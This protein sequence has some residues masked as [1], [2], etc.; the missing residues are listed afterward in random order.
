MLALAAGGGSL[1]LAEL[2]A[3]VCRKLLL[4]RTVDAGEVVVVLLAV[5]SR[6][7]E[8]HRLRHNLVV[9]VQA[10]DVANGSEVDCNSDAFR[11]SETD[12]A[13]NRESITISRL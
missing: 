7:L 10:R 6:G 1:R 12:S 9:S 13:T 11:I 3:L 5:L 8:G 2:G 4:L